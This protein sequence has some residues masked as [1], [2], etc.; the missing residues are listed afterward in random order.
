VA[1]TSAGDE[2]IITD[3]PGI[4]LCCRVDP[5]GRGG[6]FGE[7]TTVVSV[8]ALISSFETSSDDDADC[9]L[10]SF[11]VTFFGLSSFIGHEGLDTRG[12]V[13]AEHKESIDVDSSESINTPTPPTDRTPPSQSPEPNEK[14]RGGISPLG[15]PAVSSDL[16]N[17]T[18][19]Y[20]SKY[21]P[22]NILTTLRSTGS[23]WGFCK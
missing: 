22:D 19:V 11:V 8:G 17:A 3:N 12:R 7:G 2:G 1:C 9:L 13:S 4:F 6:R 10:S 16:R 21:C 15:L 18:N 20:S 14:L 5:F 23:Q